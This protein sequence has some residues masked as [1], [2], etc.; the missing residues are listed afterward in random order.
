[1]A[2]VLE[3]L[4]G[5]ELVDAD[6]GEHAGGLGRH[7]DPNVD[8]GIGGEGGGL[9]A[10]V[11]WNRREPGGGAG[12]DDGDGRHSR[13]S[14]PRPGGRAVACGVVRA[15]CAGGASST[16]CPIRGTAVLSGATTAR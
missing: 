11:E 16:K 8:S 10:E 4:L 3:R 9:E 7:R 2:S 6:G 12:G 15:Y 5:D 13:G 1:M 14:V